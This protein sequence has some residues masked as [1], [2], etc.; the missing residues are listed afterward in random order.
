MSEGFENALARRASQI[1]A[2]LDDLTA[3]PSGPER[4]LVEAM[5]HGLLGP[6]KRLRAFLVLESAALFREPETRALRVAAAVECIHAYSLIHDDLPSMDDDALRR[7]HPTVHVAFDEATAILAGDALQALA[8]EVL[9]SPGAYA[10]PAVAGA[11]CHRLAQASGA[12]GM[13]GGQMLDILAEKRAE[14]GAE[15]LSVEETEKLQSGK[16]GALI[17]FAASAGPILA[18]ASGG[19]QAALDAYGARIGLAF[20]IRDDLLDLEGDEAETGKKLRKDATAGKATFVDLL[21]VDGAR[22]RALELVEAAKSALSSFGDS[23][24][25]LRQA[26]DFTVERLR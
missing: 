26:A 1:N 23:A 8:F 24:T 3:L 7:G 10:G 4:R 19:D 18:E 6:G 9:A 22:S 5:R 15:P 13:V 2:T 16:T 20:Q 21:G 11:L 12:A 25:L 17:R 14:E